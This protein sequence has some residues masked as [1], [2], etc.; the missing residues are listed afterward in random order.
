MNGQ[1]V[2]RNTYFDDDDNRLNTAVEFRD[3]RVWKRVVYANDDT[4][5][6]ESVS[7]AKECFSCA[8]VKEGITFPM[9]ETCEC[10]YHVCYACHWTLSRMSVNANRVCFLCNKSGTT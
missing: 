8:T 3:G 7:Q 2:R 9:D 5:T 4:Y 6:L 1:L 10:K